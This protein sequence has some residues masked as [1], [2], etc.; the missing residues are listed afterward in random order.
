MSQRGRPRDSAKEQFWRNTIRRWQRSGL[1]L[2]D[3]C[4]EQQLSESSF[5]AW[6]RTIARRE[7]ASSPP[8]PEPHDLL[9]AFVPVRL[10]SPPIPPAFLTPSTS[11][12]E[13]VLG[14]GRIVRVPAGF[15][16]A[17]LRNL[18]AVLEEG[19]SC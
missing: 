12:L 2:R 5:Q 11:S 10:T 9:P 4:A 14:Q 15:D 3:F 13:L 18:L 16:V 8:V 7:Q 6:R 19:P 1:S 17:T